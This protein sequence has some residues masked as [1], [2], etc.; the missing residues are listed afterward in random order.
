MNGC[1]HPLVR[2]CS[3]RVVA[4]MATTECL[5]V[6]GTGHV[7]CDFSEPCFPLTPRPDAAPAWS[8]ALLT[9]SSPVSLYLY[10]APVSFSAVPSLFTQRHPP[11]C[12]I[13]RG[14]TG[15]HSGVGSRLRCDLVAEVVFSL[16]DSFTRCLGRPFSVLA[17]GVPGRCCST[18]PLTTQPLHQ[19]SPPQPSLLLFQLHRLATALRLDTML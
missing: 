9:G 7:S 10:R 4:W 15:R 1:R 18:W 12:L 6:V 2:F 19:W 3:L 8:S 11:R 16:V 5:A 13:A 17:G 14:S